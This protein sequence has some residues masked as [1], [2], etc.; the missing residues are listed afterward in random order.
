MPESSELNLGVKLPR[1]SRWQKGLHYISNVI[2]LI[3]A[4]IDGLNRVHSLRN[5]PRDSHSKSMHRFSNNWHVLWLN[6]AIGL[7]LERP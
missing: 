7:D 3:H 5:M 4:G 6:A 1:M 2:D